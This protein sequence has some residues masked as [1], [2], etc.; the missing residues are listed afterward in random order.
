MQMPLLLDLSSLR[1]S[2]LLR[3]TTSQNAI[4]AIYVVKR[5]SRL[6]SLIL[7]LLYSMNEKKSVARRWKKR[8]QVQFSWH[9]QIVV[10]R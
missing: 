9:L 2:L 5:P 6:H 3:A 8:V 4:D 10:Q 7:Q 1:Y